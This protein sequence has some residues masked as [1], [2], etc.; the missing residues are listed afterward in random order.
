MIIKERLDSFF[1]EIDGKIIYLIEVVVL[2]ELNYKQADGIN[3]QSRKV[4]LTIN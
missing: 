1:V 2:Y 3:K 4:K